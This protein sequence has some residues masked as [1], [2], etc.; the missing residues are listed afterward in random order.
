MDGRGAVRALQIS[1]WVLIVVAVPVCVVWLVRVGYLTGQRLPEDDVTRWAPAVLLPP[2]AVLF[3]G[4]AGA[5]WWM[6]VVDRTTS[7]LR[8]RRPVTTLVFTAVASVFRGIAAVDDPN[9]SAGLLSRVGDWRG[10]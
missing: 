1:M 9:V 8:E 6:S 4:M 7:P 5:T 3:C 10:G 2:A